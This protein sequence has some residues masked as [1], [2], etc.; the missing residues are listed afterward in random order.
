MMFSM[1]ALINKRKARYHQKFETERS[2]LRSCSQQWIWWTQTMQGISSTCGHE[3]VDH[4]DTENRFA[5]HHH[6]F[7]LFP[8]VYFLPNFFHSQRCLTGCTNHH[9]PDLSLIRSTVL[10]SL[11]G[12]RGST[13]LLLLLSLS[14]TDWWSSRPQLNT[15]SHHRATLQPQGFW[16][17]PHF[18]RL[19]GQ[20]FVCRLMYWALV[21]QSQEIIFWQVWA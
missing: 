2:S 17:F 11:S 6:S 4:E 16:K 14:G 1:L 9:F 3:K 20:S 10:W 13:D 18:W 15:T 19:I 8:F 21:I 7:L 12:G 5:A